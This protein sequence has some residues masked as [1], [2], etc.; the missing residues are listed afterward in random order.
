MLLPIVLRV[1]PL[2][3]PHFGRPIRI[4]LP[5]PVVVPRGE[6]LDPA[7]MRQRDAQQKLRIK[8]QADFRRAIKDCDV[9][10]GDTELIRQPKRESCRRHLTPMIVNKKHHSMLTAERANRKVTRNSSHFKKLLADNSII[11]RTSHAFEGDTLDQDTESIPP[12]CIP[13]SVQGSTGSPLDPS[14]SV[15]ILNLCIEGL[16][17]VCAPKET[18]PRDLINDDSLI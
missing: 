10:V 2:L 15:E 3:Q 6:S 11:L 7:A 4:K 14:G 17:V 16:H 5:N 18:H 12:S 9:K 8:S 1:L 13:V